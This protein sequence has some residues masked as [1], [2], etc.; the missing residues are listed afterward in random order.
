MKILQ[1]YFGTE[2][3]RAVLFVMLALLALFSFLT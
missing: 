1:K 3:I 2:I